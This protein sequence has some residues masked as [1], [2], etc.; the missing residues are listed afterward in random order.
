M[1][2]LVIKRTLTDTRLTLDSRGYRSTNTG[3]K[4]CNLMHDSPDNQLRVDFAKEKG[5]EPTQFSKAVGHCSREHTLSSTS[6]A[7]KP[8]H[9]LAHRWACDPVGYKIYLG[10]RETTFT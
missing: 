10:S 4:E 2:E 5:T 6:K 8:I 3:I 9:I 1:H 7:I